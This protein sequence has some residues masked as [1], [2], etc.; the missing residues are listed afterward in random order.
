ML[1][2]SFGSVDMEHIDKARG[3][4]VPMRFVFRFES[5][6]NFPVYLFQ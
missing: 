5:Q 3:T 4:K 1:S 2:S 6:M